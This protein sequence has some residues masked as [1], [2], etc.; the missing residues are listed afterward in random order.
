[1]VAVADSRAT[2][3]S[4]HDGHGPGRLSVAELVDREAHHGHPVRLNWP[5]RCLDPHGAVRDWQDDDWPTGELPALTPE[6][7][8]RIDAQQGKA[9][10][11]S[12]TDEADP[13]PKRQARTYPPAPHE[14]YQPDS[15]LL[16]RLL[17]RL[18]D[19]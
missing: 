13:L 19:L 12:G 16:E 2:A 11:D 17:D 6:L 4:K 5:A 15:A 3:M 9:T 1:V 8:A 7:L 14:L 18:R 10:T